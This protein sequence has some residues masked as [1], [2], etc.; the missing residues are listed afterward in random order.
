V[1]LLNTGSF[2]DVSTGLT[3]YARDRGSEGNL[4]GILIH[5]T[6]KAGHPTTIMADSGELVHTQ[7]GANILV[8]HGTRQEMDSATGQISQLSF[9]SYMVDLS[10]LGGDF[11]QRWIEPRERG[12]ADLLW[13][14]D[15]HVDEGLRMRLLSEFHMRLVFPALAITFT[16]IA[17]VAALTGAF[18][19][20]G[21]TMRV[22]GAALAIVLL[23]GVVITLYNLMAKQIWL[24]V[25][26]YGVAFL[27]IPLL[28][29]QLAVDRPLRAPRLPPLPEPAS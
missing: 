26:L 12:M 18:D 28:Y 4:R 6:R 5:D 3:F 20:R 24:V 16:L 8:K 27:P 22:I 14:P 15:K 2:T 1:L 23:E 9:D 19:R 10:S 21:M 29:R 13:P 11:S 7:K 17:C 25:L